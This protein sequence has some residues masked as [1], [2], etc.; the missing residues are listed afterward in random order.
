MTERGSLLDKLKRMEER[1]ARGKETELS[2]PVADPVQQLAQVI[3]LPLWP[4]AVR[5]VPN[6]LL[7]SALFGAIKRGARRY[8]ERQEVH[9]QDGITVRYTGARL[10][11]GDLDVWETV[12]HTVRAQELG[13]DCRITA[14]QLL[15]ALDKRDT[16]G[17]RDVLERRLARLKATALDVK[18]GRYSYMGSLI[19]EVYR[20]DETRE[21]VIRLN[22]K[23][24]T[25]F[26][27]DQFT[28][29]DWSVR[30]ALDGKPLAQW[31]H[32]FYA[33]HAKPY[34]MKVE[35]LHKLCGSE[36]TLMSDFKKDLRRALDA[37]VEASAAN[38]QPFNY[39]IQ[40]DLVCVEKGSRARQR[41][42]VA[43]KS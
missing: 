24:H 39:G 29:V 35:T 19:D 12:L 37:V 38:G 7:R 4:E 34:P 26:V 43:D 40:G 21:Y 17:N 41:H 5:G 25:L 30:H 2:A 3:R 11:Q 6:G 9:A 14:Y 20:D 36:A 32:G 31:L 13:D 10:D 15:K 22:P 27:S 42:D 1:N 18:V 16:G 33:S 23:L 28:Q 8:L